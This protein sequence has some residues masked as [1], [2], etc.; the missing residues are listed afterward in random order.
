MPVI[1]KNEIFIRGQFSLG[2]CT[3]LALVFSYRSWILV[4]FLRGCSRVE[5]NGQ[6][7]SSRKRNKARQARKTQNRILKQKENGKS[8]GKG[9]EAP[10]ELVSGSKA[11]GISQSG[12]IAAEPPCLA[13]DM[14]RRDN[15]E[16]KEPMQTRSG[17]SKKGA[18]LRRDETGSSIPKAA[19]YAHLA[20]LSIRQRCLPA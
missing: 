5:G 10:M 13:P 18:L 1:W 4:L 3:W 11:R 12:D 16:C 8:D 15:T 14:P 7:E 6:R 20:G 19:R 2:A 9:K 17:L